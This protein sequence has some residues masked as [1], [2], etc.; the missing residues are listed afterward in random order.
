M[1]LIVRYSQST[2]VA[3]DNFLKVATCTTRCNP[4]EVAARSLLKRG[5][6][7]FVRPSRRL[8][9]LSSSCFTCFMSLRIYC[10]VFF[11]AL[12][13]HSGGLNPN[14]RR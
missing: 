12:I 4:A 2:L 10:S 1:S 11:R 13:F 14:L 6:L 7:V 9:Y 8:D 5:T 3:E